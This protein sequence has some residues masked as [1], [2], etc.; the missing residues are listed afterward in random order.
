MIKGKPEWLVSPPLPLEQLND[1]TKE[2]TRTLSNIERG[3]ANLQ[4]IFIHRVSKP[5]TMWLTLLR[6]SCRVLGS[7]KNSFR[8]IHC[9]RLGKKA[10]PQVL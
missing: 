3:K 1:R 6:I 8:I 4:S 9:V 7:K 10:L 5:K 2:E